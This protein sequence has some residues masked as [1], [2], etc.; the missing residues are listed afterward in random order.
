[1][2]KFCT[3]SSCLAE[4]KWRTLLKELNVDVWRIIRQ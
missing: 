2:I 4:V 3:K 1:M